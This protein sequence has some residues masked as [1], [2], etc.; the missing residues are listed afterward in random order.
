MVVIVIMLVREVMADDA[1]SDRA[2]NG[3]VMREM[4][5]DSADGCAL[6]ASFRLGLAGEQSRQGKDDDKSG[7]EALHGRFSLRR[8]RDGYG[9][10]AR[11]FNGAA[12][13]TQLSRKLRSFRER[14]G[15]FSFLSA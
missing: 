10:H 15:C 4:A 13:V 2:E 14:L 9:K 3:V 7:G 1:A 6:E 5:S 11:R 8:C 12:N